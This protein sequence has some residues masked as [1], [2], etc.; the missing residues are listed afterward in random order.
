MFIARSRYYK[1]AHKEGVLSL[2][3]SSDGVQGERVVAEADRVKFEQTYNKAAA[4]DQIQRLSGVVDKKNNSPGTA[5]AQLVPTPPADGRDGDVVV[6]D[7]D[8]IDEE[9][10]DVEQAKP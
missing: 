8:S 7:L 6:S 1:N 2:R 10:R 3:M 9:V 4:L 5:T